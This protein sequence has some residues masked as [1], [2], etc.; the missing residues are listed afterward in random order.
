MKF[1][2]IVTF[3]VAACG[4]NPG[5]METAGSREFEEVLDIPL[6]EQPPPPP[7]EST[8]DEPGHTEKKLRKSGSIYFQSKDLEADYAQA[9]SLLPRFK[10]FISSENQYNDPSRKNYQLSLR[11]ESAYFDSLLNAISGIAWRIE[12]R[13]AN[14]DDVTRT[15]YDLKT[16]IDNKKVLEQRYREILNKANQVKDILEI[17]KN[18]NDVREEIELMQGQFNS[19]SRDIQ[20]S[21]LHVQFY[22]ELPYAVN[23]PQKKGF[24]TRVLNALSNGWDGLLT[25]FVV[26]VTLWPFYLIGIAVYGLVIFIKGRRRKKP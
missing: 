4:S 21:K 18:I 8:L 3:I 10:A 9:K 14:I 1:I 20:Y 22:E 12:S 7:E 11:V 24:G 13:T 25:I 16:R 26:I 19:L 17:E 5:E 15:Y 2:W 23:S 6:T